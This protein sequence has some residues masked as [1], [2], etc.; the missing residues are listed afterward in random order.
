MEFGTSVHGVRWKPPSVAVAAV[1]DQATTFDQRRVQLRLSGR[2][3]IVTG[4]GAGLGRVIAHRFAAEGAR[5]AVVDITGARA[6]ADAIL[7]EGNYA[8][9]VDADISSE[10]SIAAMVGEAHARFGRIDI[11]INNAAIASTVVPT[12]FEQ[13]TAEQWRRIMDVNVIGVFLLC[14]ALAPIMRAQK[15][16]RIVNFSSGTTLRGAPHLMHYVAS[17]GAIGSMTLAL[18]NEL[19]S[20]GITVNAVAPG[21]ILTENNLANESMGAVMREMVVKRRAIQRD[22]VPEDVVGAAL[23]F[24]SDDAAFVSS[25]M[26]VVNG[27]LP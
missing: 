5:V 1:S 21:Y 16:G 24:A 22:G 3:A 6:T 20:D 19:G 15:Y 12:P 14:R 25:Q 17:K 8:I 27:G 4:A 13:L 2:T 23:F 11:L 9:A 26:L 10:D 18:A 7:A